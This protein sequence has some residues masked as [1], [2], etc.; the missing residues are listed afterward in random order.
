MSDPKVVDEILEKVSKQKAAYKELD[1]FEPGQGGL[2]YFP[3]PA[4]EHAAWR[5]A[6]AKEEMEEYE[7]QQLA[8]QNN[9]VLELREEKARGNGHDKPQVTLYEGHPSLTT[10][11]YCNNTVGQC[12]CNENPKL[13]K[14]N[15]DH[16][17]LKKKPSTNKKKRVSKPKK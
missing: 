13:D 8:K 3:V 9:T 16:C 1:Q 12:N 15:P 14:I 17:D 4:E 6:K 10:C 5:K 7:R 2:Q 11:K